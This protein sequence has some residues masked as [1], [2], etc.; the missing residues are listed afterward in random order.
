LLS[1]AAVAVLF[2]GAVGTTF[3]LGQHRVEAEHAK[4]VAA[5]AQTTRMQA[6]LS[7][8]DARI[9]VAGDAPSGRLTAVY[10]PSHEA[11]WFSFGG[12]DGTPSGR[13]YQ[14]WRVA[15][16]IATSLGVLPPGQT[17]GSLLVDQVTATDAL[18]ISVEKAGGART[19]TAVYAKLALS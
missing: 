18:A 11:A 10:S 5:Q 9:R 1:A 4:V 14:L 7:A 3:E 2:L 15:G 6:V 13:T 19:P 17:S 12:L 16:G 8:P